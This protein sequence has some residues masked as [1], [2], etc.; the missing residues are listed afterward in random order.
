LRISKHLLREF[1]GTRRTGPLN[2]HIDISDFAETT[3]TQSYDRVAEALLEQREIW[4]HP[5]KQ[6]THNK[7]ARA[8][9]PYSTEKV[10]NTHENRAL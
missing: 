9:L 5:Q 3:R 7:V 6:G 2:S 10:E 8:L 4:G 1:E